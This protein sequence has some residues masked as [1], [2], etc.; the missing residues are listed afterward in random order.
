MTLLVERGDAI[1]ADAVSGAGPLD[2]RYA[3]AERRRGAASVI[4]RHAP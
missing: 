3:L 1:R 2:A 4:R